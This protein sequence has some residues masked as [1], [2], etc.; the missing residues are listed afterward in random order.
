MALRQDYLSFDRP[1][2]HLLTDDF[3]RNSNH[4]TQV[5]Y[6]YDNKDYVINRL[7]QISAILKAQADEFLNGESYQ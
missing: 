5:P 7:S 3:M 2:V 6:K 4:F 1:Y